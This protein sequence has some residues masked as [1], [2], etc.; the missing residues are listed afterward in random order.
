MIQRANKYRLVTALNLSPIP[1]LWINSELLIR[2][3]IG[4]V[5]TAHINAWLLRSFFRKIKPP[6]GKPK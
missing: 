4:H 2:V 5:L 6:E 3:L 1:L